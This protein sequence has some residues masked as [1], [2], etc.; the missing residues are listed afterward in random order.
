MGLTSGNY[1]QVFVS[2]LHAK[3]KSFSLT[4]FKDI[5]SYCNKPIAQTKQSNR[6]TET[7]LKHVTAKE[8]Y[9]QNEELSRPMKL[10]RYSSYINVSYQNQQPE[11]QTRD[12]KTGNTTRN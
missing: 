12:N 11:V 9:F 8:K 7:D 10:K 4:S 2:T 3:L 1:D 5:A 6:E